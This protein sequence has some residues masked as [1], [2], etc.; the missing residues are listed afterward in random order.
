MD[1]LTVSRGLHAW[2]H[3]FSG[4]CLLPHAIEILLHARTTG[5]QVT[6]LV[7]LLSIALQTS[8]S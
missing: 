1:V 7:L 4:F 5:F 8:D 6:V 3:G 2:E